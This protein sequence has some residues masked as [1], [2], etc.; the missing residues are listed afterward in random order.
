MNTFRSV[1]QFHLLH[2]TL[3]LGG[4]ITTACTPESEAPRVG[5]AQ[6]AIISGTVSTTAQDAVVLLATF[7]PEL[8]ICTGTLV[9]PNLVL[10]ARHC[11]SQVDD[12][13]VACPVQNNK[14]VFGADLDMTKIFVYAGVNAPTGVINR[15]AAQA[16]GKSLVVDTKQTT[17]CGGDIALIVLDRPITDKPV[18]KI[19]FGSNAKAGETLNIVGYGTTQTGNFSDQRMTRAVPVKSVGPVASTEG[20]T[21][22]AGEFTL[23]EGDCRGDTV[24]RRSMRMASSLVFSHAVV[25]VR[26]RPAM[27]RRDV[28]GRRMRAFARACSRKSC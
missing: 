4:L 27:P 13:S 20:R 2:T 25:E 15:T 17:M 14:G 1:K 19:R 8:H 11:T 28:S 24:D 21:L 10:T 16:K 3:L 6:S 26:S 23:G 12:S 18:A 22:S 9:A 5:T 7:E